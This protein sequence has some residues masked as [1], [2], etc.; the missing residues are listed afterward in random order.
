[1]AARV[2]AGIRGESGCKRVLVVG[3]FVVGL[4]VGCV[5]GMVVMGLLAASRDEFDQSG[6]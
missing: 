1:M 5:L 3:A 2:G 4:V 6:H